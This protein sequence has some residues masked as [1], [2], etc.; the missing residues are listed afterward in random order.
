MI[1]RLSFKEYLKTLLKDGCEYIYGYFNYNGLE[2]FFFIAD[3]DFNII[4]ETKTFDADN[5]TKEVIDAKKKY[6]ISDLHEGHTYNDVDDLKKTCKL[7]MIY[8]Y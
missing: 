7:D 1:N 5:F 4:F 6:N 3:L 2:S 8:I